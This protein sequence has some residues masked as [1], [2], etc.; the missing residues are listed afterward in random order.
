MILI[1][2][3]I[4][5]GG[6]LGEIVCRCNPGTDLFPNNPNPNNPNP[7]NNPNP[8]KKRCNPGTDLSLD[9]PP[10]TTH[11]FAPLLP[12]QGELLSDCAVRYLFVFWDVHL[13]SPLH[14]TYHKW[15]LVVVLVIES[16]HHMPPSLPPPGTTRTRRNTEEAS[17]LSPQQPP[18]SPP[19]TIHLHTH[20][21]EFIEEKK[22]QI[23]TFQ[24]NHRSTTSMTS[25][26]WNPKVTSSRY[27]HNHPGF[28]SPALPSSPLPRYLSILI[29]WY[30]TY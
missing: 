3:L 23:T 18:P 11:P 13:D 20:P 2:F 12:F 14:F 8:N 7:D 16:N 27:S 21:W 25:S 5:H 1:C 9:S 29:R 24:K 19:P 6:D 15:I 4:W 22:Y 28:P 26:S 10:R 30:P 17:I